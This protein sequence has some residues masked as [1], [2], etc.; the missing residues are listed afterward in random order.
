[1][2]C[3]LKLRICTNHELDIYRPR[4]PEAHRAAIRLVR[5]LVELPLATEEL[6]VDNKMSKREQKAR[7]RTLHLL[8]SSVLHLGL[9]VKF[10]DLANE[11]TTSQDFYTKV[12]NIKS[13]ERKGRV[14][15]GLSNEP[16]ADLQRW[17]ILIVD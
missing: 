1:M 3:Q 10:V 11:I 15:S 9:G 7:S 13:T 6:A 5:A 8:I 14:G 4:G 2:A 17:L 16:L 12:I